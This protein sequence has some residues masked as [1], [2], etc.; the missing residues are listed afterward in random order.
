MAYNAAAD[1]RSWLVMLR[2]LDEVF[3]GRHRHGA[4]R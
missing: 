2:L 1:R 3:D 4:G